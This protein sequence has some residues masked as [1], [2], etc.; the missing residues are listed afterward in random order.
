MACGARSG[1]KYKRNRIEGCSY[2]RLNGL[3]CPFGID[4]RKETGNVCSSWAGV[5]GFCFGVSGFAVN[6]AVRGG[7]A[8]RGAAC[9]GGLLL[10]EHISCDIFA[11][12]SSAIP[13]FS[14]ARG[15]V[16]GPGEM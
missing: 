10:W 2:W 9:R 7:L 14:C 11:P 15:G 1:L 16:D 6:C 5:P 13:G 12:V 3:W 4:G 8:V